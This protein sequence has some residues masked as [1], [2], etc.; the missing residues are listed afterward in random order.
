MIIYVEPHDRLRYS[1][2]VQQYYALR[3]KIFCYELRWVKANS[4]E[5]EKDSFDDIYSLYVL[6]CDDATGD[7]TGGVRLMPTTGPTLMHSVWKEMLPD[8]DDFRSPTIWEATRFC[9]EPAASSRKAS[10]ANRATLA[11]TLA[12]IDF[13]Q[14]NGITHIIAV[15]ESKFFDMTNAYAGQ[16]DII[17]RHV[18]ENGVDICCGLWSA[19]VDRS[20]IAWAKQFIGGTDPVL[21]DKVA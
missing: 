12:V 7:V 20:R 14:A 18:D 6:F 10:L 19:E 1:I 8:P 11:L 21:L 2:A 4:S 5:I 13:A 3:K 16:A 17:S 9:V 15:C